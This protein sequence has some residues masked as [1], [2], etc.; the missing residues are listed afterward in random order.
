VERDGVEE[1]TRK[2]TPFLEGVELMKGFLSLSSHV[3]TEP[4]LKLGDEFL[5]CG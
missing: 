4:G 2:I 1:V 3:F 5:L